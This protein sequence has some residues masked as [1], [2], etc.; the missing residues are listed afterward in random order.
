VTVT[1]KGVYNSDLLN[2]DYYNSLC[3]RS[4]SMQT[5]SKGSN[6]VLVILQ[7]L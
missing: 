3:G 7:L 2:S 1:L 5:Y 6:A 4:G